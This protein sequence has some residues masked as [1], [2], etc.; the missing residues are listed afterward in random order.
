MRRIALTA[1]AAVAAMSMPPAAHAAGDS[2]DGGCFLAA[3]ELGSL[4]SNA[5]T[6]V[7]GDVSATRDGTGVATN[8]TVT[9][10]IEVNGGEVAGTR[11]PYSGAGAQAGVNRITFAAAP[12][13]VVS[14]CEQVG[15]GDGGTTSRCDTVTDAPVPPAAVGNILEDLWEVTDVWSLDPT[16]CPVL[17]Q[18]RGDYGPVTVGPDG[19]VYVPD[20]IGLGIAHLQDCPPYEPP[21]TD[22]PLPPQVF[23]LA[24]A[25]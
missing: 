2:V 3:A 23:F 12:T 17:Q 22:P 15:Y 4:T 1:V 20:P 21:T 8:A 18:I 13:D 6:G 16:I 7:L 11:F 25:P 19:D 24:P 5:A 10:W 9:C 14:V